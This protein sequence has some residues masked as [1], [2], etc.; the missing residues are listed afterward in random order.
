MLVYLS[1]RV[2]EN[3]CIELDATVGDSAL[4]V[5]A[6]SYTDGGGE[7]VFSLEGQPYFDIVTDTE[8][9]FYRENILFVCYA[10]LSR[11]SVSDE[12]ECDAYGIKR[13]TLSA[14]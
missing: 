1:G 2:T 9:R 12:G 13:M 6:V 3:I 11:L 7:V 8:C 10:D 5:I 14:V 4:P